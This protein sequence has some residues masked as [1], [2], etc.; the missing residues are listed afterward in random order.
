MLQE[1]SLELLEEYKDSIDP[2]IFEEAKKE[3]K[4]RTKSTAK[5]KSTKE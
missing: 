3:I 4:S 2:I 5:R 1:K